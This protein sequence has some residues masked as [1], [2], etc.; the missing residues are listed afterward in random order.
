MADIDV[1]AGPY[2]VHGL[3]LSRARVVTGADGHAQGWE[4]YAE[5][6]TSG[7]ADEDGTYWL[8]RCGRSGDKPFCDGSHNQGEAFDGTEAAPG[9]SYLQRA[10]VYGQAHEVLD[11]R[12]ICEHAGF[13]ATARTNVWKMAARADDPEVRARMVEMVQRCP[14]G[15]L[16]HR[17]VLTGAAA[18]G[19]PPDLV[20]PDLDKAVL[21]VDDGPY[22]L[23]GG[24]TLARAD[25]APLESRNR[26]TVCRCGASGIKPLCDAS[27][28]EVDFTDAG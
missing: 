10:E 16:T 20:E 2:G 17:P 28:D 27:H 25:G 15:A 19:T 8:C 5:V 26:M 14:S 13:C 21:V 18:G 22:Y 12:G 11:D 4:V 7:H 24:V 23:T 3:P 6:D 9:G 1:S